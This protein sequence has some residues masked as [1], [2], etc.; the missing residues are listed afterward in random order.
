MVGN[1]LHGNVPE[2]PG[3]PRKESGEFDDDVF[4]EPVSIHLVVSISPIFLVIDVPS[5]SPQKKMNWL[6]KLIFPVKNNLK[7]SVPEWE[8]EICDFT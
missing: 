6:F 4:Y 2:G 5:Q 3:D 8:R 7:K 1:V